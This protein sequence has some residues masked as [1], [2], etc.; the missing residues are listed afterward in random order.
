MFN[1]FTVISLLGRVG[2]G[3]ACAIFTASL[4]LPDGVSLI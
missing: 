1:P 3:I 2:I 4:G